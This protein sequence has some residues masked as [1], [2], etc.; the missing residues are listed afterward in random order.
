MNQNNPYA[1]L[2]GIQQ[3]TNV[4]TGMLHG[5]YQGSTINTLP[6]V[7]TPQ[8]GL[9]NTIN[10]SG[11]NPMAIQP[12]P[13]NNTGSSWLSDMGNGIKN[14]F[15]SEPAQ[16]S[17]ADTQ[18][19]QGQYTKFQEAN[20]HASMSLEDFATKMSEGN[21]GSGMGF[22]DIA[23]FGMGAVTLGFGIDGMRKQQKLAEKNF[24]LTE[25]K[26]NDYRAD[27]KATHDNA[28]LNGQIGRAMALNENEK[29]GA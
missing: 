20:P 16:L 17:F 12:T 15:S 22:N 8:V 26:Y 14:M 27:K 25:R 13:Q 19:F 9:G 10:K 21:Q 2:Q 3:S 6:Q 29:Q 18:G 28:E 7:T 23:N 1:F 5:G 24:A 4:G 11:F